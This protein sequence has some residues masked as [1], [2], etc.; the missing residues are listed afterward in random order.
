MENGHE[1]PEGSNLAS[2]IGKLLIEVYA[3]AEEQGIFGPVTQDIGRN[4]AIGELMDMGIDVDVDA[5]E[6]EDPREM[7]RGLIDL[8]YRDT[9]EASGLALV[10]EDGG[11]GIVVTDGMKL[12]DALEHPAADSDRDQLA[13]S[14]NRFF[15]QAM[16]GAEHFGVNAHQ[17]EVRQMLGGLP[18]GMLPYPEGYQMGPENVQSFEQIM[19]AAPLLAGRLK[20]AGGSEVVA[21]NLCTVAAFVQEGNLVPWAISSYLGLLPETA[22]DGLYDLENVWTHWE[23]LRQWE[24]LFK[25]LDHVAS[26]SKFYGHLMRSVDAA[27]GE[28]EAS[29]QF[30]INQ[31]YEDYVAADERFR[32]DLREEYRGSEDALED[33]ELSPSSERVHEM[34]DEDRAYYHELLLTYAVV[35]QRLSLPSNPSA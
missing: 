23:T 14:L 31:T 35:R 19:G 8:T 4:Q 24:P 32:E 33:G 13:D 7:D 17:V 18:E 3:Y 28:A 6:G 12:A 1:N 16:Y 11:L 9:L 26:G 27:L 10:N 15:E 20:A 30:V 22:P 34:C 25:I 5:I 21:D 29:A 2:N